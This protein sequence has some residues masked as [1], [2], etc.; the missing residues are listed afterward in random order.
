[1]VSFVPLIVLSVSGYKTLRNLRTTIHPT[2]N[3][4]G[5]IRRQRMD[6]R[7]ARMLLI[8]ILCFFFQTVIFFLI[9]IYI[10][11]TL[12]W[13]KSDMRIAIENLI[14]AIGFTIYN[15]SVSISFY[16][17]YSQSATFRANLKSVLTRKRVLAVGGTFFVAG[18]RPN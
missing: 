8:Q 3:A 9:Y 10:T 16:I 15:T 1:M 7:L 12:Y 13:E 11:I 14:E 5:H 18:T 2:Q 4:A 6:N 17:Y